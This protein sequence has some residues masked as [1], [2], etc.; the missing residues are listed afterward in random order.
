MTDTR[1]VYGY[2]CTWWDSIDKCGK[3]EPNKKTGISIPCCPHCGSPLLEVDSLEEW[4][5]KVRATEPTRWPNY[6]GFMRWLRGK[7]IKGGM[8]AAR[9]QWES[10]QSRI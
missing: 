4:E 9:F 8:A 6:V 1:I 2:F 3:T 7:C 10:E 5:S